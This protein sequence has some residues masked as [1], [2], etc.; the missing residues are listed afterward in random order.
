MKTPPFAV[1]PNGVPPSLREQIAKELHAIRLQERIAGAKTNN[2]K[3]N[4]RLL[5]KILRQVKKASAALG[6]VED[7]LPHSSPDDYDSAGDPFPYLYYP[8]PDEEEYPHPDRLG[9]ATTARMTKQVGGG[10]KGKKAV[11]HHSVVEWQVLPPAVG[12]TPDKPYKE[13]K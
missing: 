12:A 7:M 1:P 11:S 8:E 9:I 13:G 5:K 3:G 2:N 4:D 10:G 6:V